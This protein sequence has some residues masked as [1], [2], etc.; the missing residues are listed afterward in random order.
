MTAN[1]DDLVER[2]RQQ[3]IAGANRAGWGYYAGKTSRIEPTCWALLALAQSGER[4]EASWAALSRPHVDFLERLQG[5]DGLLVENEPALV[6]LAVNG[7]ASVVLSGR[8]APG[9][10]AVR[11]KLIDALVAVKGVRVTQT[12]PRQ[13]STL[14]GWPWVRD[15]FSWV[16]PT[17]WCL[18]ALKCNRAI[19]SHE[20]VA[21]R[22][23]EAERVLANRMCTGGGWNYG[24]AT[25]F[26]QDLRAYVPTTAVGL[27]ALQDRKDTA[28][29]TQSLA[30]LRAQRLSESGTMTLA[31][32]SVAL[33][34]FGE[35]ADDVDE[36]LATVVNASEGSGHLHAV[37]M[38]LYALCA[39][40]HLG[41]PFRAA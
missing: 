27:L 1:R 9:S 24:N 13:D 35:P 22:E 12:D 5:A 32:V 20:A 29:V 23:Q 31:L 34:L 17:A 18:L 39:A 26:G 10:L 19:A 14:Q 6:N 15:T 2:L 7:L 38:A 21:A 37:A 4:T 41:E 40:R 33:R 3:L 11:R 8:D 36:R 16:E 25:A 30:W 28:T